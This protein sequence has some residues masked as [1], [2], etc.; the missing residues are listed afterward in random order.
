[1]EPNDEPTSTA[2]EPAPAPDP[3]KV[4]FTFHKPTPEQVVQYQ[5]IRE[6]AEQ[7]ARVIWRN[8]EPGPDRTASL[9]KIRE[10]VMTA[11]A[12]IATHNAA[13]TVR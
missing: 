4:L 13:A 10:A 7:L 3:I 12:S 1:M 5:E 2:T 9:R 8:C 6:Q 11:N